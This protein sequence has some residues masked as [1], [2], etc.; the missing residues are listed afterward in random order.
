MNAEVLKQRIGARRA[1]PTWAGSDYVTECQSYRRDGS[2]LVDYGDLADDIEPGSSL[3]L[4]CNLPTRFAKISSGETVL[5]LG[6]G[7]GRMSS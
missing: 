1:C 2:P 3:G 5:D 7:G 4:G 6:S